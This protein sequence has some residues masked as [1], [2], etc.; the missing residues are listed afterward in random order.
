MMIDRQSQRRVS[1]PMKR[2]RQAFFI[3]LVCHLGTGPAFAGTG[4]D[5]GSQ[6]CAQAT[7]TLVAGHAGLK[8]LSH[9]APGAE[10]GGLVVASACKAWPGD[11][12]RAI[13]A[14]AYEAGNPEGKGLLVALF[15]PSRSTVIASYSDVMPEDAMMTVGPDSLRIDTARYKLAPGVHAFGLDAVTS[16]S[17][18]CVSGGLG[19]ARTLFVQDGKAIRPVLE[20]FYVSSWRYINDEMASCVEGAIDAQTETTFHSIDI[21]KSVRHGFSSLRI[22][23]SSLRDGSAKLVRKPRSQEVQYDGTRYPTPALGADR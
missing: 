8:G 5:A 21:G 10:N 20:N 16:F 23:S 2:V 19:P 14:I 15:D 6:Q 18:G 13:A 7:L 17:Q 9:R 4:A 1:S 11:K 12:S 22:T 3:T